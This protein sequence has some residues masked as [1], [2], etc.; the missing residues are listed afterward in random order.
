MT[1]PLT[2]P[3]GASAVYGP[4]KGADSR[5]VQELDRALGRLADVI[6]RDMGKDVAG[7]PGAGAAGGAG[8]GLIAFLDA[9]LVKGA[10]LVVEAAGLDKTLAGA[11]LVI[12][13]SRHEILMERDRFRSQ[14]WAAFDAFVPGSSL[15]G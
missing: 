7:V 11:N 13:G 3:E 15:Y 9:S 1:N 14:F 8:A 10:P 4:Q 2:G 6:A 12:S 5:V